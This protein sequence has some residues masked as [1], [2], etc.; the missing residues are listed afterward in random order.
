MNRDRLKEIM[1]GVSVAVPTPFDNQY[2]LDLDTA[3]D[4]THWWIEMGLGTNK[5]M[6]KLCSAWGQ[7]PDLS[8]NE[9]PTLLDTVVKA[10][11]SSAN[12]MCGLK[13]RDT[14]NTI[15]DARKAQDLG[16]NSLQIELPYNHSPN[17]DQYVKHFTMI[18][19]AIEIG[20]MIY[21]TYWFGCQPIEPETMLRL[22]DAEHVAA[23]KWNYPDIDGYD[24]MTEFSHIFNVI[25][26]SG[27]TVR[28]HK[29]GGRGT[30]SAFAPAYAADELKIWE[31]VESKRYEEAQ[32]IRDRIAVAF[33][34]VTSMLGSSGGGYRL[35]K[36]MM[37]IVGHSSGPP[38][39]PTEPLNDQE[40]NQL[41][42]A[43]KEIGWV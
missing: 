23:V 40:I 26:N 34:P 39:L 36:G 43:M 29:N 11:G 24:R 7:G 6:I 38:R 37:D 30:V 8:D 2:R 3:V 35:A 10:A 19:D 9:W 22:Q 15:E 1:Q 21:N 28:C 16:A 25:D 27:Q 41:R 18:S 12:I 5:S 33:A 31:L 14:L 42:I 4:L 17:Q 32:I 20:I 13:S